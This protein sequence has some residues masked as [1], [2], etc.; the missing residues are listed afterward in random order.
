MSFERGKKY[1]AAQVR[2][3]TGV[4]YGEAAHAS[5]PAPRPPQSADDHF[6]G[7]PCPEFRRVP[8]DAGERP[9]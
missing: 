3:E 7:E 4:A 2:D 1:T 8:E 6:A 9:S 5:L